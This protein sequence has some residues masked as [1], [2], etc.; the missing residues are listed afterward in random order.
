MPTQQ[1]TELARYFVS[2]VDNDYYERENNIMLEEQK[3]APVFKLTNHKPTTQRLL[4]L[5]ENKTRDSGGFK[6]PLN[7]SARK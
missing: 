2:L 3:N 5:P 4:R 7:T 1:P 6:P